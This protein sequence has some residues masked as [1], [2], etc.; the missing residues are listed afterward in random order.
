[1]PEP[2]YTNAD[3]LT[4]KRALLLAR[5]TRYPPVEDVPLDQSAAKLMNELVFII[6]KMVRHWTTGDP[7]DK[8]YGYQSN[9]SEA[10]DALCLFEVL[11]NNADGSYSFNIP[12]EDMKGW[13]SNKSYGTL[14]LSIALSVALEAMVDY[15]ALPTKR[16]AFKYRD[17]L[18]EIIHLLAIEGYVEAHD[19]T[20]SWTEKIAPYMIS[21]DFWDDNGRDK[22]DP[23]NKWASTGQEATYF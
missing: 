3:R 1:M 18:E 16:G 23:Q 13:L 12:L 2:V 20:V 5:L 10:C 14:D 4:R 9:I 19:G 7:K 15:A 11:S 8:I 6:A 22:R 17:I 21:R